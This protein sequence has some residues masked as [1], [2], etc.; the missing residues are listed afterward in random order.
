MR[1]LTRV[2]YSYKNI[3]REHPVMNYKS[4]ELSDI[5]Q[6]MD[7]QTYLFDN[8]DFIATQ[9]NNIDGDI[10]E[11]GVWKGGM[12]AYMAEVF[13]DRTVWACDSFQGCPRTIDQIKYP[14]TW[15]NE[16][17]QEHIGLWSAD[18]SYL[19]TTLQKY[20]IPTEQVKILPGWF[21]DTLVPDVCPINQIAL[22]RIDGDLYS[23]TYEVLEY[24]YPK[25]VKGGFVIFDDYIITDSRQA[26]YDY[27]LHTNQQPSAWFD[28]TTGTEYKEAP[29]WLSS[30]ENCRPRKGTFIKK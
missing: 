29:F 24:L 1:S 14:E 28:P 16:N 23:S 5:H 2:P 25:V 12:V 22:L 6:L 17:T 19:R 3:K 15:E 30:P 4:R 20:E 27:F 21:K 7:G 26:V 13:P 10:V 18:I 9:I 8:I 11:C